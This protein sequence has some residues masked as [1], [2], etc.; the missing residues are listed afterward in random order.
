MQ[1]TK[2]SLMNLL[3]TPSTAHTGSL[4]DW[5]KQVIGRALSALFQ[6]Q[7]RDE[8][9]T[10]TTNQHNNIGF[11]GCDAKAGSFAAKSYMKRGT[12]LDF[13][14]TKWMAVGASGFPR[15]VKYHKQ[16]NEIAQEKVAAHAA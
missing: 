4:D 3:T 14:H 12:L 13:Q 2:T 7:T 11:A 6:R 1:I 10:N 16:L 15:I 8:R 5:Q 9:T